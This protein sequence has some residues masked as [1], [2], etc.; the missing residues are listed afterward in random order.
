[1]QKMLRWLPMSHISLPHRITSGSGWLMMKLLATSSEYILGA[2][3]AVDTMMAISERRKIFLNMGKLSCE[4]DSQ[5][6]HVGC[7][8][9]IVSGEAFQAVGQHALFPDPLQ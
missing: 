2:A 3:W 1:M 7:Y 9:R 6:Y 5:F 4:C 8:V